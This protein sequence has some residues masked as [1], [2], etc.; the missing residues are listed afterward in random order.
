MS[1]VGKNRAEEIIDGAGWT[2]EWVRD[3][4]DQQ[5]SWNTDIPSKLN[6]EFSQTELLDIFD[7]AFVGRQDDEVLEMWRYD[8][9]KNSDV[10]TGDFLGL[11]N[12]IREFW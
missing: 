11:K 8:A 2:V 3:F 4:L 5:R 10:R 1:G 12:I 7:A 9:T 6:P